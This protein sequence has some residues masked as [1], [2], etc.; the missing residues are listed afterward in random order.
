MQNQK[1][2][3]QSMNCSLLTPHLEQF[4]ADAKFFKKLAIIIITYDKIA[5]GW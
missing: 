4:W 3:R 2:E 1:C 5:K